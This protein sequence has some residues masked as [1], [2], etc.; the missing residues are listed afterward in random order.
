MKI[1]KLFFVGIVTIGLL[2]SCVNDEEMAQNTSSN[3][4]VKVSL[5]LSTGT[6]TT[7]TIGTLPL[8]SESDV[9]GSS[10]KESKINRIC[11]GVFNGE[12][13]VT[14]YETTSFSAST[15]TTAS[16]SFNTTTDAKKV[17]IAA[18]APEGWF[19]NVATETEFKTKAADLA[20]TT[21]SDGTSKTAQNT[22]AGQVP[23]SLPM[24]SGEETLSGTTSMTATSGTIALTRMVARVAITSIITNFDAGLYA[25][26]TFTPT[27]V[28]MYNP[29]T[30][31]NWDGSCTTSLQK[32]ESTTPTGVNYIEQDAEPTV[33]ESLTNYSYLSTGSMTIPAQNKTNLLSNPCY[34]YVF[35]NTTATP[36]KLVIK[37]TWYYNSKYSVVYYPIIINHAQAG[38]TFGVSK[39]STI[40]DGTT[41]SQ[42]AAN[43]QYTL[44]STIKGKGVSSPDTDINPAAISL[45]VSVN[46]WNTTNQDVTFE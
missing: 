39:T 44:T 23:T 43:T 27:E 8:N 24:Y 3:D 5:Q 22:T 45:T 6:A 19:K 12:T 18:N 1:N 42:V 40:P 16:I 31:C 20:Y 36:T 30:S 2:A 33:A 11:V 38:T 15:S 13:T 25:G 29:N 4:S 21:S 35:P 41:D 34:F 10:A 32:C 28:F 7:R 37:G 26:A 14:I 17:I 46:I 9:T